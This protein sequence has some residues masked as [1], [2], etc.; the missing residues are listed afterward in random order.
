MDIPAC[1]SAPRVDI[2]R[3]VAPGRGRPAPGQRTVTA[4]LRISV[5]SRKA[6]SPHPQSGALVG[7]GGGPPALAPMGVDSRTSGRRIGTGDPR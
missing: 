4:T 6:T 7:A 5:A 3:P 1:S 2:A